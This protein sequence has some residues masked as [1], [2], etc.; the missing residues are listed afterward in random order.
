MPRWRKAAATQNSEPNVQ[1]EAA[2]R[3]AALVGRLAAQASLAGSETTGSEV[4]VSELSG[5]CHRLLDL[6]ENEKG[7][8]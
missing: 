5:G 6:Q 3:G 1:T 2:S 8:F 7:R 4:A